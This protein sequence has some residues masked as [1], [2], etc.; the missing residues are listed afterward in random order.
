MT[1]LVGTVL[2]IL[3]SIGCTTAPVGP[4]ASAVSAPS[5]VGRPSVVFRVAAAQAR[6]VATLVGFLDAFNAGKV[7]SALALVTDDIFVG[8]CDY[9]QGTTV[10]YRGRAEVANW[11]R[12]RAEDGDRILVAS[13]FNDN[14]DGNAVGLVDVSRRSGSLAR[15]GFTNGIEHEGIPKAAFASDGRM[16]GFVY[17]S[18]LRCKLN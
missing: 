15:R 3:L 10:N 11:L 8:D 1:R 12:T 13:F 16:L 18:P 7:D 5:P 2:V 6:Q 9:T 17:G 4:S 14:P